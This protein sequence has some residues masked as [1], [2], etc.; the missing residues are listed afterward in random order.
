[1]GVEEGQG[2][3]K[4]SK[5]DKKHRHNGHIG[6][7][8]QHAL[9]RLR[10]RQGRTAGLWGIGVQYVPALRVLTRVSRAEGEAPDQ[11]GHERKKKKKKKHR[12][13]DDE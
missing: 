5:K 13:D 4:K 3:P 10:L 6:A 8:R 2:E 7:A 11:N 12:D 1:M 9:H